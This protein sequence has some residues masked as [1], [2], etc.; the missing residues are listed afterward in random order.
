MSDRFS[1][2]EIKVTV[3]LSPLRKPVKLTVT[4]NP[5]EVIA[6]ESNVLRIFKGFEQA[7]IIVRDVPGRCLIQGLAV[8]GGEFVS[9]FWHRVIS[10]QLR[11]RAYYATS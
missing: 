2:P 11:S 5:V 1:F 7:R 4:I 6:L 8:G 3:N 10:I 9:R